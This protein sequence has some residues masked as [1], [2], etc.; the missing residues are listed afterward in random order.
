[1]KC[2]KVLVSE[3]SQNDNTYFQNDLTDYVLKTYTKNNW[4][5]ESL[6]LESTDCVTFNVKRIFCFS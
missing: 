1:M 4:V 6:L 5:L 3:I 2:K